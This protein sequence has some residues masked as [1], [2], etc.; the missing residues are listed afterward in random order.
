MLCCVTQETLPWSAIIFDICI[1]TG[2]L[3]TLS[4][5]AAWLMVVLAFHPENT[6]G[7]Y[8]NTC[9]WQAHYLLPKKLTSAAL[10]GEHDLNPN[11]CGPNSCSCGQVVYAL[12]CNRA[13]LQQ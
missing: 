11:F 10:T 4:F 8:D 6:Y 9:C 3:I 12:D 1:L 13:C 2:M 7:V 5:L